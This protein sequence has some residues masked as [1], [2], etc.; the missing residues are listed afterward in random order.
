MAPD[1]H[2]S[3]PS[4]PG[5]ARERLAAIDWSTSSVGP[6]ERWP[7]CLRCVLDVVL[8]ARTPMFI[9]WGADQTLLYN[10][11]CAELLGG[12]SGALGRPARE[13]P[14]SWV[15][16]VSRLSAV[17]EGGAGGNFDGVALEAGSPAGRQQRWLSGSYSPITDAAGGVRGVCCQLSE[18]SPEPPLGLRKTG[19]HRITP[20][21]LSR[22]PGDDGIGVGALLMQAPVGVSVLAGPRLVFE[23]A[24]P[25]YLAMVG[26]RELLGK[27]FHEAFPELPP[28]APVLRMLRSVRETGL[29]FTSDEYAVPLDRTGSGVVEDAYFQFT[30]QALDG[31]PGAV[32]RVLTVAMEVTDHVRTRQR[33]MESEARFR[34]MADQAPMMVWVTDALARCVFLS[35]SWYDFVGQTAETGLGFGWLSAVHP[36]DRAEASRVF[37]GKNQIRE[38][39]RMEYRVRRAD[40]EYR[41]AIDS[42]A[43]RVGPG[44]E[45][46]GYI[47]SVIDITERRLGEEA[48]VEE[49]ERAVRFSEVFAGMLGHDLRNPLSAITTS[50]ELLARRAESE[51]I[52]RPVARILASAERMER[53]IGQLLDFTRIR[54]GQGLPL[55]HEPVDLAELARAIIDEL[56]PVFER[57]IELEHQGSVQGSWDR[58]RL[59]QLLS[60]LAANACQHGTLDEPIVVS[61]DGS[62][63]DTVT[64]SVANGGVIPSELLPIIFE[65][66]RRSVSR[67]RAR[68]SDRPDRS[69]GLGLGLHISEQIAHALDGS[70]EVV[71][72]PA[73]GTRFSVVLPRTPGQTPLAPLA[74]PAPE[75]T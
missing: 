57:R 41:W 70:I 11:A 59:S 58:D 66:F 40:G 5:F 48:R 52:G 38:P 18:V 22:R 55:E 32:D 68:K 65:P 15:G 19:T 13:L 60:N 64:L 4:V 29:P 3:P 1:S 36:D 69:S 31:E 56:E 50:A 30:C 47:G 33:L 21:R 23:L 9:A 63:P 35:Q 27:P 74:R 46:L 6:R 12:A 26:G 10:D 42:A 53:M 14:A 73:T 24:N 51:K 44:G 28:D 34:N 2:G 25:R 49:M 71:S 61:L 7:E 20:A 62:H 67:T 37:M 8:A 54:L 45:F 16:L 75:Q 17:L 43:P 39:F 72:S